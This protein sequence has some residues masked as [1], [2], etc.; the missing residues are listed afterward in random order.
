MGC[1]SD[2]GLEQAAGS[3]RE[4]AIPSTA[5]VLDAIISGFAAAG[6]HGI[7]HTASGPSAPV[8]A[9]EPSA[10][11]VAAGS[12]HHTKRRRCALSPRVSSIHWSYYVET[13]SH[14][15]GSAHERRWF[16]H[17]SKSCPT[18]EFGTVASQLIIETI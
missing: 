9:A 4:R 8:A 14:K 17:M 11:G 16:G 3:G 13:F 15:M 10:T 5:E 2:I 7:F 6:A 1:I 12:G 18:T